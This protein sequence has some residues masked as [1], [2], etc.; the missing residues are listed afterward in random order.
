[1]NFESTPPVSPQDRFADAYRVLG[2][3]IAAR[4]FPGCAFGVLAGGEV[5]LSG[6]LGSFTYDAAIP[7]ITPELALAMS[8]DRSLK[9][10]TIPSTVPN[11]PM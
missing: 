10:R 11:R 2:E 6:A 8:F 5:V 9:A 7:A 3:A 1:M 4:A